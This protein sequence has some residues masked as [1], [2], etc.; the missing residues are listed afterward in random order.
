MFSVLRAALISSAFLALVWF[1]VTVGWIPMAAIAVYLILSAMTFLVYALDKRAARAGAW[2]T[3]ESTLHWMAIAG[4]WPGAL[5]AQQAL[6]H[7][8]KKKS[9]RALFWMTVLVNGSALAWMCTPDG[10]A[11]LQ[12]WMAEI[13][14]LLQVEEMATIEWSE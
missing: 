10:N 13:S 6:R 5:V 1:A 14:N 12:S 8:S 11:V 9:F 7:K 3:P 4:G 2:R